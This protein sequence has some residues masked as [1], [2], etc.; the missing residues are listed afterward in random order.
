M[1][2]ASGCA[3]RFQRNS[4]NSILSGDFG[5][6]GAESTGLGSRAATR[7]LDG[8]YPDEVTDGSSKPSSKV[9][10]GCKTKIWPMTSMV[11][12]A[13]LNTVMSF[14]TSHL[15]CHA[16]T[17]TSKQSSREKEGTRKEGFLRKPLYL[18]MDCGYICVL[19]EKTA[20]WMMP[21]HLPVLAYY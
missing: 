1:V 8:M 2:G 15:P 5:G 4:H 13:C 10:S 3:N 20:E 9:S 6:A 16:A 18:D 11:K 12:T 17:V 7:L 14:L 21:H 19:I